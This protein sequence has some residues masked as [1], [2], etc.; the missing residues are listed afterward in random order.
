MA[1][2]SIIPKIRE[3]SGSILGEIHDRHTSCIANPA[4]EH[5][6]GDTCRVEPPRKG[7]ELR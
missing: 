6:V 7:S 3:E 5:D 1:D 4:G 2:H